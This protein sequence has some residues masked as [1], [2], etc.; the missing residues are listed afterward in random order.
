MVIGIEKFRKYFKDFPDSYVIIGGTACDMVIG[1]AGLTPRATKD[2]DI[3]LIVEALTSDFVQQFWE[4]IKDGNYEKSEKST[5]ERK[6]YR[7][8]KPVSADFP[9]QIELF[10]RKPDILKMEGEPHLTP[11]PMD[12]DLSS[13]SAILLNDW[14]YRFTID[15]SIQDEDLNRANTEALICLKAKAFLDMQ[16]RKDKGEKVDERQIRKH[17]GDVFRLILIVPSE[18]VFVLPEEIQVDMQLFI[19][20]VKNDLP[21]PAIFKE[22]GAGNIDIIALFNQLIKNFNLKSIDPMV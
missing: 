2:I 1:A 14:Y 11:I 15:H 6:Y 7:F 18:M 4:F 21:D 19:N 8:L 3:I 9:Y 13:L 12:D 5:G 10:S 20:K 22:M 16:V 17:K